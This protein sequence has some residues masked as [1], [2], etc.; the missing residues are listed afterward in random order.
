MKIHL[1]LEKGFL[2]DK[3]GKFADASGKTDGTPV[4]S[5][6][7]E[8]SEVPED[9]QTLALYLID[10]DAVPVSGF[11]WIHWTA[12]NIPVKSGTVNIPEDFS[13]IAARIGADQV[14]QGKNS[15][16]SRF[17]GETDPQLTI[18]YT[19]PT[20]PNAD[21]RYSLVVAAFDRLL[22]L[23]PGFWLNELYFELPT[24][25]EIAQLD[26]WSRA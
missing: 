20:P 21:H 24:A 25:L 5:F 10:F 7:V 9:A 26:F 14:I 8:I 22:N 19:G 18:H 1:K 2:P 3:Y 11:P 23:Q 4:I 13:R 12:A 16:A 17:V 6:P 15:Q